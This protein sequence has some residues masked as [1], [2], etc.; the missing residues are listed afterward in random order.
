MAILK[1]SIVLDIVTLEFCDRCG[2]RINDE[3][4]K[5]DC[6][7]QA[8]QQKK[9]SSDDVQDTVEAPVPQVAPLATNLASVSAPDVLEVAA[10]RPVLNAT[11]QSRPPYHDDLTGKLV[12]FCPNEEDWIPPT[13]KKKY[14]SVGNQYLLGQVCRVS[15]PTKTKPA[16]YEVRWIDTE[17]NNLFEFASKSD[18]C[19]GIKAQQAIEATCNGDD[20]EDDDE[21]SDDDD[22]DNDV[23]TERVRRPYTRRDALPTTLAEVEQIESMRFDPRE[24]LE[25]PSNLYMHEDG[26]TQ[27]KVK[28]RYRFLF[29]SSASAS[30]FAYLPL[31]FWNEV[32]DATNTKLRSQQRYKTATPF[33][34]AELMKF[35]GILFYMKLF[36]KGEYSKHWG[37]QEENKVLRFGI[38]ASLDNVMSLSRF[39]ALRSTLSFVKGPCASTDPAVRIRPILNML[40]KTCGRYVTVGRDIAIDESSVSCRSKFGRNMIVYNPTKPT[41]KYHFKIYV[42]CC[43]TSWIALNFRVHAR[44]SLQDRLEGVIASDS[45]QRFQVETEFCADI[46]KI[47]LEVMLPF[48]NTN[49]VLNTDNFYTSVLLLQELRLKGL[50]A[51]GTVRTNSKH[52]PKHVQLAGSDNCTRGESK[53]AVSKEYKT[54]ATSWCDGSIVNMISNADPST[55]TSVTRMIKR[56]SEVIEAPACVSEY[57]QNMQAVDRLDQYMQE[58]SLADGHSFQKWYKKFG[59]AFIDIARCNA[60]NTRKLVRK[61]NERNPHRSF[62]M[63]LAQ[64]F[65]SGEWELHIPDEALLFECEDDPRS[66]LLSPTGRSKR[67]EK[68]EPAKRQCEHIDSRLVEELATCSWKKRVCIVCKFEGFKPTR[69]TS[70]CLEHKVCLCTQT[71]EGTVAPA[72][73]CQRSDW[74]CWKK[75]HEYYYPR[76]VFTAKG[77]V[78]KSSQLYQEKKATPSTPEWFYRSPSTVYSGLGRSETPR[79]ELVTTPLS[80]TSDASNVFNRPEGSF[81]EMLRRPLEIEFDSLAS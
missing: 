1:L 50:Y 42:A 55:I 24:Q 62:V 38:N 28:P 76:G 21:E 79:S 71:R 10:P 33:T 78:R 43:S 57:N 15:K 12:A 77:N 53:I 47:V 56:T 26:S 52:F 16:V 17:F 72:Y 69:V 13:R 41:G 51:R 9:G 20:E 7:T 22:E 81:T 66:A 31:S 37:A 63:E 5:C 19:R 4:T 34:M 80:L 61:T 29:Q 58:F 40:K 73:A 11:P 70:Y 25:A 67:A 8:D 39:K 3:H 30:F 27:T 68:K 35:L 46:R 74:S 44:S 2:V 65:I 6:Q 32:L 64:E 23:D 54:M 45:I 18:I 14:K 59:M 75:F 49:R 48:Y 60:Y 36:T